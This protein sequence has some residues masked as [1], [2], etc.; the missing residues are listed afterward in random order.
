MGTGGF[1]SRCKV[2]RGLTVVRLATRRGWTACVRKGVVQAPKSV[3]YVTINVGA[4]DLQQLVPMFE[5]GRIRAPT[6]PSRRTELTAHPSTCMLDR[7]RDAGLLGRRQVAEYGNCPAGWAPM[8]IV[9]PARSRSPIH[10][11]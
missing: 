1:L 7:K 9:T 3:G 6:M 4:D 5:K 8:L 11:C 2:W 10:C